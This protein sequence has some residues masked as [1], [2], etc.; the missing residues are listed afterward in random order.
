ME[1]W[2]G[3]AYNKLAGGV[4][5]GKK[6]TQVIAWNADRSLKGVATLTTPN[7]EQSGW[8]ISMP[9]IPVF[10]PASFIVF[11]RDGVGN[12]VSD[13]IIPQ[14]APLGPS[15]GIEINVTASGLR[16]ADANEFAK[17]GAAENR[18]KDFALGGDIDLAGTGT[19]WNGPSGYTGHFYGNGYTIK[20]LEL[21]PD[22]A[23]SAGGTAKSVGLFGSLGNGAV[24]ED[25]SLEIKTT[26]NMPVTFTSGGLYFGGVLAVVDNTSAEITL[27]K[28]KVKG[29]LTVTKTSPH[30]VMGGFFGELR[31]FKKVTFEQCSSDVTINLTMGDNVKSDNIHCGSFVGMHWHGAGAPANSEASFTDCA[32]T[33]D[34]IV[35]TNL[36]N[37]SLT[38][39]SGGFMGSAM[40]ANNRATALRFNRCY[41]AGNVSFTNRGT[42]NAKVNRG[43]AGG[44]VG[45]IGDANITV[46]MQKCAVLGSGISF[47]AL[48]SGINDVSRL[49]GVINGAVPS[50]SNNIA[51]S[52]MQINGLVHSDNNADLAGN[53]KW[54]KGK[55]I[56]EL[57]VAATW[58]DIAPNGLG[59]NTTV[60]NFSGLA[61]GNWPVLK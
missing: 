37:S 28:I 36:T 23:V 15:S 54:G 26:N 7:A 60:W 24:L 19:V 52:N 8:S 9:P 41:A 31:Q 55:T 12:Y 17:L 39:S 40:S 16:I 46:E 11:L 48:V 13:E 3:T 57:K 44:F 30:I 56:D 42:S 25:F 50:F 5:D 47:P 53:T 32:A 18:N 49:A 4:S 2:G 58:T 29:D 33:G 10:R 51:N 61:Q 59:W 1:T 45:Y 14:G 43:G 20:G 38:V 6:I 21:G 22:T 35:S 34:I 27:K